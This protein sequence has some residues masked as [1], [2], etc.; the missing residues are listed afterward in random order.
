[1]EMASTSAAFEDLP[2]ELQNQIVK[3]VLSNDRTAV[4]LPR[5]ISALCA[6]RNDKGVII[7]EN[8][9]ISPCVFFR[10]NKRLRNLYAQMLRQ[11][12]AKLDVDR[13]VVRIEDFNIKT[14]KAILKEVTKARGK[15]QTRAFPDDFHLSF[16]EEFLCDPDITPLVEFADTWTSPSVARVMHINYTVKPIPIQYAG[17][18]QGILNDIFFDRDDLMNPEFTY[19][20]Q[21][22]RQLYETRAI[23]K[24]E[25]QNKNMIGNWIK[26]K[27][28]IK[29]AHEWKG[30]ELD[31]EEEPMIWFD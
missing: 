27:F 23:V 14:F 13:I 15:P 18:L 25:D 30:D 29:E 10:V 20:F 11:K 1:M 31:D 6:P 26:G 16:T 24:P 2:A 8:I 21:I 5:Q 22:F 28:V 3:L 12:V 7:K 9:V 4:I 19:L 17:K